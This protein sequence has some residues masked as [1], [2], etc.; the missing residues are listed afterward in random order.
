MINGTH[1]HIM[2]KNLYFYIM[3]QETSIWRTLIFHKPEY[4]NVAMKLQGNH[5]AHQKEADIISEEKQDETKSG[6][7]NR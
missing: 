7:T 1:Q 4:I 3:Q 6:Y 2:V 5:I